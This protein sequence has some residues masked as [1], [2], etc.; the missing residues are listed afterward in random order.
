MGEVVNERP[1]QPEPFLRGSLF[2]ATTNVAYPR[3]NPTDIDQLPLDVWAAAQ[4][5]AGV[6]IELV[7]DA[8]AVQIGYTTATGN[9][10]YRGE[11]A[12]CTFALY[13]AS[14]K[15]SEAEAV[16]GEGVVE[17]DLNGDADRPAV[18][19]LPEGMRPLITSIVGVGG[20]I[21][22]APQL[23]R[24]LA[25]GDAITQGWLASCPAMA[26]PAVAARK[27]GLNLCNF[28]YAGS[29][30]G[31]SSSAILLADTPAEVISIGFG[32]TNWSRVPHSPGLMAE[33]IRAFLKIVRSGHPETPVV[34]MSPIVRPDAEN[35]PNR[36]GATLADLRV[37]MEE[38]VREVVA[39]GD[40]RLFLTEGASVLG[41]ADLEDGVYPGDEGHKRLAAAISKYL[42]P[43]K[44]ELKQAA[45][46]RRQEEALALAPSLDLAPRRP[47]AA[48]PRRP[49]AAPSAPP[50][51]APEP[52]SAGAQAMVDG[53]FADAVPTADGIGAAP[54]EPVVEVAPVAVPE[55]EPVAEAEP[56]PV[57]EVEP[58][59]EA[60]VEPVV[61]VEAEPEP[62]K[63][64][65]H[66]GKPYPAVQHKQYPSGRHL[67]AVAGP[68]KMAPA[69][70]APTGDD[71]PAGALLAVADT[72]A[73]LQQVTQ[74]QAAAV[75]ELVQLQALAQQLRA[76]EAEGIATTTEADSAGMGEMESVEDQG[77]E[78]YS[79]TSAPSYQAPA[80]YS[81][82]AQ[83]TD[84]TSL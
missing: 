65:A 49:A 84:P 1:E 32:H 67:T 73:Q 21:E 78:S 47:A 37:A 7:G 38:S 18:I 29:A 62:V 48:A 34:V 50:V 26:W 16:L 36:L 70:A 69:V 79:P 11:A 5:P 31:E 4:V 59:V 57:A 66:T 23:P 43:L 53:I 44:T 24:W 9:L 3:A 25:Y 74:A 46:A 72:V 28:G 63:V 77:A 13:K 56:E 40:S 22:P 30:R 61:E 42:S 45:L 52:V 41:E 64:E 60:E 17:L 54:A 71:V 15:I 55:V 10:G 83:G 76:A 35:E 39:A 81:G 33:E 80:S 20:A 14:Q 12:G 6:R 19:Y 51:R 82:F 2:P 68:A 8:Q 58:V 27:L 75:A